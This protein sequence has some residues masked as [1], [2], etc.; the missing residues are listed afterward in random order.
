MENKR[1]T[2][3]YSKGTKNTPRSDIRGRNN[4]T[5]AT[6]TTTATAANND[7]FV[8]K[9]N[10]SVIPHFKTPI[11]FNRHIARSTNIPVYL[12]SEIN[13]YSRIA[14]SANLNR[15]NV[16]IPSCPESQAKLFARFYNCKLIAP[17]ESLKRR[18][19]SIN[20]IRCHFTS[21]TNDRR[22]IGYLKT[23]LLD[24]VDK[25]TI[26]NL[27]N[28]KYLC[29]MMQ[30]LDTYPFVAKSYSSPEH[31]DFNSR[32][33]I[34]KVVGTWAGNGNCV[35]SSETEA[36]KFISTVPPNVDIQIC[37]YIANPLLWKLDNGDLV[38]FHVRV[39]LIVTS[40][41]TFSM[42]PVLQFCPAKAPFILGDYSNPSVHDTHM[43]TAPR[44]LAWP[45]HQH[46]W[47]DIDVARVN[48]Q[49]RRAFHQL[50]AKFTGSKTPKKLAEH[51]DILY[52]N[53]TPIAKPYENS[54][55]GY[56][57]LGMDI[58][59]SDDYKPWILEINQHPSLACK[60]F[61]ILVD[62]H[63]SLYDWEY[64]SAILP[65][66]T[67]RKAVCKDGKYE[68]YD[69]GKI[70]STY[71][72]TGDV[73]KIFIGNIY[74]KIKPTFIENENVNVAAP[75]ES[76]I[77]NNAESV[78]SEATNLQA[79]RLEPMPIWPSFVVSNPA[80][81]VGKSAPYLNAKCVS[82]DEFEYILQY[83]THMRYIVNT[84]YAQVAR[85]GLTMIST[86]TW[87]N[88]VP[89]LAV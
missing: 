48:F 50:V 73:G 77:A 88:D 1:Y 35:V 82:G 56:Q 8:S 25:P 47:G 54:K 85:F 21:F 81:P 19:I 5:T 14:K 22:N 38:K 89:S 46:S 29:D 44:Q 60:S 2:T 76:E 51:L 74:T 33:Y 80:Y 83:I 31:V 87:L 79:S 53:N 43:R 18:R 15:L 58:M 61:D 84:D 32:P 4:T 16:I 11:A 28:K 41:N 27:I 23:D 30:T 6:T 63:D 42:W 36:A 72:F 69:G 39:N 7:I 66:I 68:I 64:R 26:A 70:V 67:N 71:W 12:H 45:L 55:Y 78:F 24:L 52:V 40:W 62:H 13:T 75:I 17:A 34:I 9:L 10:L 37:E 3:N 65:H 57:M 86:N 59:F 49:I 20:F